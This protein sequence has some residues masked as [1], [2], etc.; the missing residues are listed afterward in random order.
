MTS[1]AVT[2]LVLDR[3]QGDLEGQLCR[4]IR[5][6]V[7]AGRL[8]AGEKLPSTRALALALRIARSTVVQAYDRLRAEGYIE[9]ARGSGTR[10]AARQPRPLAGA[11]DAPAP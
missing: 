9:T 8:G 5:E 2:W 6:R 3:P 10:V 7:L 11:P 1:A 4:A